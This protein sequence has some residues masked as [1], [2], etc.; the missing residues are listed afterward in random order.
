VGA[1]LLA[2][3]VILAVL[4]RLVLTD[5]QAGLLAVRSRGVDLAVMGVLATALAVLSLWVPPPA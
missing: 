3:S 2:A 1:V 4:M 5:A